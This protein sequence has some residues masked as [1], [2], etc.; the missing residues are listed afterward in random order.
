M[1]DW[2]VGV[3]LFDTL[4]E[5]STYHE[6]R[7]G[8]GV[9]FGYRFSGSASVNLR[10]R[11]TLYDVTDVDPEASDYIQEQAGRNSTSAVRANSSANAP[12]AKRP[13]ELRARAP[14]KPLRLRG[15]AGK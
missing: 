3:D 9:R 13:A 6:G 14:R 1:S 2:L 10:Y 4:K 15:G 5:Y 12:G 11:Y 8:G 7:T